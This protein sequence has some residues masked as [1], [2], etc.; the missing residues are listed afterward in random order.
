MTNTRRLAAILA[1]DVVGYSRLMGADEEGTLKRLVN[2]RQAVIDPAV[3]KSGGR[4]VKTAGDGFLIEYPS[5]VEAVRCGI[6]IQEQVTK[7]EQEQEVEQRFRFR[8]GINVGDVI[9]SDDD[10]HGDGVN[11]AAR[12]ESLAE[13]GGILVSA[14]VHATAANRLPCRFEDLGE[15]S[16]KNIE[17]PV[18]VYRVAVAAEEH[19]ARPALSLPDKPSIAVLPF[20]NMSGDP[21]QEYFADGMVEDITTALS[22]ISGL[23]VIARNSAFT[24]KGRAIDVRQVG[25]ELG[26]RYVLEG[27][28]RKAGNRVRITCQLVETTSG[29]H[30]WAD[31]FDSNLEDIFELQD[32]ITGQAAGAFEPNLQRAEIARAI[33]KPTENLDAY[34]LFLRGLQQFYLLTRQGTDEA[35]RLLRL[36]IAIDSSF[37]IAKAMTAYCVAHAAA[38]TWIERDTTLVAEG[39]EWSRS[40]LAN[41][42]DDPTAMRLAGHAVAWLARDLDTGRVALD[43]AIMLN[44]NSAQALC[45]S[46]WVRNYLGDFNAAR[47]H[48]RRA[49]KLSPLDPEL[50]F[51]QTGLAQALAFGSPPEPQQGLEL[52]ELALV[53]RPNW[54]TALNA[55]VYCLVGLDRIEEARARAQ[56]LVVLYPDASLSAIRRRF[57]HRPEAVERIVAALRKAEF[58]E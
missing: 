33:V 1:A 49:L 46:G 21:E 10:I 54:R 53:G 23:F 25:R 15:R 38:A 4:I 45:S 3:G 5:A 16:L 12:L 6:V 30:V 11:I 7:H 50:Y 55:R 28:V 9:A 36:A 34:D 51:F 19:T 8:I 56:Q 18:R 20:Q 17:K 42:P 58:P 39:I 47:D 43:R 40:A 24:Y 31:R 27:S 29:A 57:P 22:R 13:P 2:I 41:A 35:L 37:W 32:T 52:A 48:L 26:V 44:S 14:T